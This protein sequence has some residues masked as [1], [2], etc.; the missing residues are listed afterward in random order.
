[1]QAAAAARKEGREKEL[2]GDERGARERERERRQEQESG[3]R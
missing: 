2:A 3:K 1:M